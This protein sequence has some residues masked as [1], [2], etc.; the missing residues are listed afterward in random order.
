MAP[1]TRKRKRAGFI[2]EFSR[3][4]LRVTLRRYH[5]P[6]AIIDL[7]LELLNW[8]DA[9]DRPWTSWKWV[10]PRP[11][12]LLV[13]RRW[14]NPDDE[15]EDFNVFSYPEEN[16]FQLLARQTI[17]RQL[18]GVPPHVAPATAHTHSAVPRRGWWGPSFFH[19]PL[20]DP[21]NPGLGRIPPRQWI[22]RNTPRRYLAWFMSTPWQ[23]Y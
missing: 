10:A 7:I 17:W 22:L 16:I 3:G 21:R 19:A 14:D 15:D 18:A 9:R 6:D 1:L 11:P 2:R 13:P 8:T 23:A 4:E 12:T 20:L 5:L